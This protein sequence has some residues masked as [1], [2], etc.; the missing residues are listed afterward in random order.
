MRAKRFLATRIR[1]TLALMEPYHSDHN[2]ID[3][4]SLAWHRLVAENVRVAPDLLDK[5]RE[6]VSRSGKRREAFRLP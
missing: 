1:A 6:N 4:R 5:A 2:R 3:E